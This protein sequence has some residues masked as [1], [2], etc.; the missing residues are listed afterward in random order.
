MRFLLFVLFFVLNTFIVYS[1]NWIFDI[2][3]AINMANQEN[4]KIIM[5]FSGS[6]WCAP[7]IKLDHEIWMQEEFIQYANQHF[8]M[9][10]VDFPKRSKGKI[11]KEQKEKNELLAEQ[12]NPNGIFPYVLVLDGEGKVLNTLGYEGVSVKDYLD[13]LNQSNQKNAQ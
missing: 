5:V 9:L 1:Q 11:T 3:E 4:K 7:C 6:D 10:R 2:D 12:F 8:I 13:L